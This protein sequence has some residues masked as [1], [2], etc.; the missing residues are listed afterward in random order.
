VGSG[1]GFINYHDSMMKTAMSDAYSQ[2][3]LA[4]KAKMQVKN[5]YNL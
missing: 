3:D 2:G 1:D 5:N 4:N